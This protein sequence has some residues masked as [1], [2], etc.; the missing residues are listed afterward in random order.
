MQVSIKR[1]GSLAILAAGSTSGVAQAQTFTDTFNFALDVRQPVNGAQVANPQSLNVTIGALLGQTTSQYTF[2]NRFIAASGPP[3]NFP[4]EEDAVLSGNNGATA[5][6]NKSQGFV[7]SVTYG[8]GIFADNTLTSQSTALRFAIG[9]TSYTGNA[10]FTY[11]AGSQTFTLNRVDYA[12][13][14][15]V[16][17]PAA[18][19]TMIAGFGVAGAASRRRRRRQTDALAA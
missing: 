5:F 6:S 13:V 11:D 19:L 12:A 1:A 9:A 7:P 18:W 10:A 15:G 2:S 8:N 16:P 3:G 17:E 14:A 4:A